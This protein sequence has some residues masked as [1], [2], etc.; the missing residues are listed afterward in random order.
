[1]VGFLFVPVLARRGKIS[2][3]DNKMKSKL[4]FWS[5][6]GTVT[7]SNFMLEV[8]GASPR[9]TESGRVLVDCGLFQGGRES[10]ERNKQPFPYDPKSIDVLV[11]T[12][13]HIDHI[14]R[15][16]KLVHD[17]FAGKIYS[18]I[19]T[20]EIAALMFDDAIKVMGDEARKRQDNAPMYVQAD[21]D[22]ALSLWTGKEYHAPF[23]ILPGLSVRLLDGG[24]I[25]GSSM[26]EFTRKSGASGAARKII[27]T[28]DSGNTP[29]ALVRDTDPL[30]GAHYVVLDSTYG[31]RTHEPWAEGVKKLKMLV[32]ETADKNGVL[33]IPAFSLERTHIILYE[34]NNMIE[35]GEVPAIPVYLDTPLANRLMPVYARAHHLLNEHVQKHLA[36]GDDIFDFPKL[37]VIRNTAESAAI[38]HTKN[39]KIIIAGSGMS[40]GGRIPK[41]EI[42]FLPDPQTALLLTGYQSV[43]TLGR[44]LEEGQKEVKIAGQ[45]VRVRAR[46]ESIKN[47]S[48]HRDM[49]GLLS[50]V[51]TA[52]EQLEKVFVVIGE[53]KVTT[54]L[55]QRIRD[56]LNINA[57]APDAGKEYEIDF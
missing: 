17:G 24:H 10:Y 52:G 32:K 7:G 42:D 41:H 53:P 26:I 18:T 9:G 15:I 54:F 28:G 30:T 19:Q 27:F 25:L 21:V 57:V 44:A 43:G 23:E 47:F 45:P 37:E 46:I 31:D 6:V 1:M 8:P 36:A 38:S 50:L 40:S 22:R 51:E 35:S 4:V 12:H 20:R 48:A 2:C 14:G 16:P 33:L 56:Y 29:A 34:L 49:D 55:T 11:V 39:P 3:Y 5:G 13:A